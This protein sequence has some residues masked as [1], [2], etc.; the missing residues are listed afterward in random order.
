MPPLFSSPPDEALYTS[1]DI[2]DTIRK[3]SVMEMEKVTEVVNTSCSE[4]K[5]PLLIATNDDFN[6]YIHNNSIE[7]FLFDCDGVLYRGTDAMPCASQTIQQLISRGKKVFFVTNNAASTR[8]ELKT[9][10]EKVLN[11]RGI[12]KED[13]MIGS[14][15]VAG[16]YLKSC[17]LTKDSDNKTRVH[18][19]GTAGLCSELQSAG[20][21]ISEGEI[22]A[23]V[24][25]LDN[26][27]NYRKLC[28]ATVLLQRNPDALLVA[29]NLDA[30]DLVGFDARH[31]PGN[32]ALVSA[33][34]MASG[35][36]AINVGKPSSTLSELIMDVYG[37]KA[38]ETLMVGDRLD[39]D[40][41]FGNDSGMKSALVLTG[42]ATS[43]DI[44]SVMKDDESSQMIP[45]VIFPHVGYMFDDAAGD[46]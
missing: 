23:L 2:T 39:T 38:E 31:L 25:G 32:G 1:A 41:T 15:Y 35:R 33:V 26:D 17:K 10:L 18:V 16:Q 19:I 22:D 42:C 28:I 27:F 34:E 13:M 14:A 43:S 20:F 24:I 45:S 40:I 12:L 21:D 7:N 4:S 8:M 44:A 29:T 11:C 37:L 46:N 30:F 9:K 36:T 3:E 6:S 5:R